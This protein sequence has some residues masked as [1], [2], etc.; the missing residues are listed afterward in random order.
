LTFRGTVIRRY[1]GKS[2]A[3][4]IVRVLDTFEGAKWPPRIDDPLSG[5]PDSQRLRETVRT[6]N[7]GL[8]M[9]RFFADGDGKGVIWEET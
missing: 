6:L 4:N 5:I 7:T 1:R 3:R 2:V 8:L 9:I